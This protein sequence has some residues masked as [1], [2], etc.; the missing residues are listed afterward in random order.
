MDKDQKHQ[1][2]AG[3]KK[4]FQ[5]LYHE[6]ISSALRTAKAITK[7]EEI[8]KDAVQEAFIRVYKNL[9]DFDESKNF[10]P[11]FYRILTNECN[12]L[13]KKEAKI[14]SLNTPLEDKEYMIADTPGENYSELY[15][16]IQSLKD[17]YRIP[18]ILKYLQGFS[19][20]EIAEILEL[21]HNTVKTRLLNGR[22]A[23]KRVLDSSNEGGTQYG[24]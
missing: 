9:A 22:K 19:E 15:E 12:R 11:W 13:M 7:N 3:D 17:I 10:L 2:I 16:A 1:I 8:A 5:E 24:S 23:L 20:K 14:F 6:H 21:K 4:S 18:I